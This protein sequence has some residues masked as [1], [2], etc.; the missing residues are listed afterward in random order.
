MARA[1]V[2]VRGHGLL[3]MASWPAGVGHRACLACLG[4]PRI[5]VVVML[6]L[7]SK[8]KSQPQPLTPLG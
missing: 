8:L 5:K 6:M 3:P 4:V 1:D 7:A 2:A